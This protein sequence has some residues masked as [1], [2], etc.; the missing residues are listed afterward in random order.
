MPGHFEP[1]I[2]FDIREHAGVALDRGHTI[3]GTVRVHYGG[4]TG[5]NDHT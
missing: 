1:L 4:F 2:S 3:T 5:T